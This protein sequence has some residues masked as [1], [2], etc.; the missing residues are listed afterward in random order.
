MLKQLL[1]WL[2]SHRLLLY[3]C[4]TYMSSFTTQNLLTTKFV[5]LKFEY[6]HQSVLGLFTSEAYTGVLCGEVFTSILSKN[7]NRN[8]SGTR[9]LRK[10]WLWKPLPDNRGRHK[11]L[12]RHSTCCNELQAVWIVDNIIV[13]CTCSYNLYVFGNIGGKKQVLSSLSF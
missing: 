9:N 12:R 10:L 7:L 13:T 4:H 3:Y 5:F 11:R 2:F 6:L 8:V 1:W